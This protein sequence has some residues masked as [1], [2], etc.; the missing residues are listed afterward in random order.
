MYNRVYN[1]AAGPATLPVEV[2]EKA[3]DEMMNYKNT[4]MSV[5]EMS[6]RSKMYQDIIE[7]AE[8]DLRELLNIPQNYKV[9]FMQGGGTTQ[10][11]CV[12][13]HLLKNKAGYIISGHWAKKA[14]DEAKIY[15]DVKILASSEDKKFT[16]IPDCSDLDVSD[17]DYVYYC[18][19]NTIYGTKFKEVPNAKGK[20]LVAD[21]SSCI[22]SEPVDVSKYGIIFAGAQK[23]IG[24]AGVTI[25]IIR[26]DLIESCSKYTPTLL[27]YKKLSGSNSLYNTPPTY[28]IYIC[29]LV[30]KY[31][32]E[33]GGLNEVYNRNLE[34]QKMLYDY[35]DSS[36]FYSTRVNKKDRSMM[37]VVFN[38]PSEELDLKFVEEAKAEGLLNLKGHKVIG[39][40]RASI[41]NSM[42][43]TG[44]EELIK[45]MKKF[46]EKYKCIK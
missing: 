36:S 26:E 45:F 14:M 37:N 27:Q 16:Y 32:L 28:N 15:G 38:S 23:N 46:E 35:L 13:L 10:F 1:F 8:K 5:M 39:G 19:N 2:L 30:F 25:V 4:G 3:R 43:I 40:L 21:M 41:Y 24:P 31:L 22:L 34:K 7:E 42:T 9:L 44:V 17:V 33:N 29:G 6:H 20:I 12:P 11:A 18:D